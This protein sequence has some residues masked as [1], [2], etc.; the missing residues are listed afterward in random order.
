[1]GEIASGLSESVFLLIT[2]SAAKG[3]IPTR[4]SSKTASGTNSARRAPTKLPTKAAATG[5]TESLRLV[6]PLR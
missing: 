4:S 1:M 5:S 2:K 6:K 3:S